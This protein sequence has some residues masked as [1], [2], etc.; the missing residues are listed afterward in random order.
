[1]IARL[2]CA[3]VAAP[4]TVGAVVGAGGEEVRALVCGLA[5]GE[6]FGRGVEDARGP[7]ALGVDVL[8]VGESGA[9][10]SF[11]LSGAA[12]VDWSGTV[13]GSPALRS[14]GSMA[15]I[16]IP[17]PIRAMMATAAAMPRLRRVSVER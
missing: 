17:M 6:E 8:G 15:A 1:V 10:E 9:V 2:S 4:R 11:V 13:T 3:A 7:A 5:G 12:E 14:S 16:R